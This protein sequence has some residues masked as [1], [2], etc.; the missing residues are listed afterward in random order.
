MSTSL[1]N[2]ESKSQ[3][4]AVLVA[5]KEP[6][7]PKIL[8]LREIELQRLRELNR[9][10]NLARLPLPYPTKQA[11]MAVL[12][13]YV[14]QLRKIAFLEEK[15]AATVGRQLTLSGG[16]AGIAV[17]DLKDDP[18]MVDEFM[19]FARTVV[20]ELFSHFGQTPTAEAKQGFASTVTQLYPDTTITDLALFKTA[21]TTN[22]VRSRREAY[23]LHSNTT[24][25]NLNT[26]MVLGWFQTWYQAKNDEREWLHEREKAARAKMERC[27]F[28][29]AERLA[30]IFKGAMD[31]QAKTDAEAPE[32]EKLETVA[33]RGARLAKIALEMAKFDEMQAKFAEIGADTRI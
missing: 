18:D 9:A 7:W 19:K 12:D 2:A 16:L 3:L 13:A 32:P 21:V 14:G 6:L 28:E 25:G 30:S 1:I 8:E 24:Y 17:W 23:T 33:E 11:A 20:G 15:N 26:A 5:Q 29:G 31:A 27:D 4:F 22:S 10:A